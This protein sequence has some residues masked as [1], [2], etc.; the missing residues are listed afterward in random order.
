VVV[1]TLAESEAVVIVLGTA[2][3][4]MPVEL[5]L[6]ATEIADSGTGP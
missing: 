3:M 5:E 1:E 4:L 6:E 2:A